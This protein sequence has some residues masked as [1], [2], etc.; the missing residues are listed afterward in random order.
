[1]GLSICYLVI[2]LKNY[3]KYKILLFFSCQF[4]KNEYYS[5][6]R[7]IELRV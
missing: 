2:N 1:M 4:N 5:L 7:K 3:K 6:Y